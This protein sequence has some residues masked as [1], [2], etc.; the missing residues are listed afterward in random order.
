MMAVTPEG[1]NDDDEDKVEVGMVTVLSYKLF[2]I[3][4][5]RPGD[6][7]LICNE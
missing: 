7:L 4:G 3:K 6:I 5:M 2:V 1:S